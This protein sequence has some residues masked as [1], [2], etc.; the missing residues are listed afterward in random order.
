MSVKVILHNK[1]QLIEN[2]TNLTV[3]KVFKQFGLLPE[4]H[5]CVRSGELLTEKDILKN[6]DVIRLVPVISGG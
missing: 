3:N 4:T 6:G 1:E 5:L 2:T